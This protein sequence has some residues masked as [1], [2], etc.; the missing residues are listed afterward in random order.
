VA[1]W[2]VPGVG[3]ASESGIRIPGGPQAA[4]EAR[5]AISAQIGDRLANSDLRDLHLLVS[6]IVNNSVLH[7]QVGADGWIGIELEL[8]EDH[9]RVEVFDSGVQG[10]PHMRQ[11]DFE[12]GGGFGLFL[13]EALSARWGVERR[14]TVT[15][16]FELGLAGP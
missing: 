5:S 4:S 1:N 14:P 3:C 11:P 16:W 13:V 12:N 10:D 8:R 6:E 2:Y 7:G 9:L 15:V